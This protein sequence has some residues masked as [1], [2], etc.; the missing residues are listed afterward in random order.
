M[1]YN[2]DY[3]YDIKTV[4]N[5]LVL[6]VELRVYKYKR[7]LL[8]KP[9]IFTNR[10]AQELL[11]EKEGYKNLPLKKACQAYNNGLGS[12]KGTWIFLLPETQKTNTKVKT[13]A[14]QAPKVKEVAKK[15][16]QPSNTQKANSTMAAIKASR[17]KG[18]K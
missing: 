18:K 17:S 6:I 8:N 11:A 15:E 4:G 9:K 14:H 3:E 1:K 12:N 16:K 5:E 10:D 7:D 2:L 13:K